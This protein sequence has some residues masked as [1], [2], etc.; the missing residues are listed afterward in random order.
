[1]EITMKKLT[2]TLSLIAITLLTGCS[3]NKKNDANSTGNDSVGA[4]S[5]DVHL[6]IVGFGFAV[7]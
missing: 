1:M 2:F 3:G 6:A 5:Q 4:K 7:R